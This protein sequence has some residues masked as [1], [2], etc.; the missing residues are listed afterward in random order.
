MS[1][2]KFIFFGQIRWRHDIWLAMRQFRLLLCNRG[3]DLDELVKLD[4]KQAFNVL[5]QVCVLRANLSRSKYNRST[6]G[7]SKLKSLETRQ[8]QERL[9]SHRNTC[10]SQSWTGP[11]V[12]RSSRPLLACRTRCKCSMETVQICKK[13]NSVI[14]S[15][16]VTGSKFVQ[17]LINGVCYFTCIWSFSRMSFNIRWWGGGFILFDKI[18]APTI[19]LSLRLL[20]HISVREAYWKVAPPS[21]YNIRGASPD[22]SD[23]LCYKNAISGRRCDVATQVRKVVWKLE[24]ARL[25]QR[26]V[27]LRKFTVLTDWQKQIKVGSRSVALCRAF[28]LKFSGIHLTEIFLQVWV[29]NE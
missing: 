11:G 9:V 15:S 17:C 22:I 7:C 4:R 28:D 1:Y 6:E 3:T 29:I 27:R 5:C 23:E 19:E 13:S 12:R 8:V 25:S 18:P 21:Q 20:L 2:T 14:T 24:S 16:W 26:E 10:K